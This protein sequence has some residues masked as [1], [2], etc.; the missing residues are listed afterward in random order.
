M[1]HTNT[2]SFLRLWNSEV[3]GLIQYNNFKSKTTKP[4]SV[5]IG[6]Q[7]V[8]KLFWWFWAVLSNIF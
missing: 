3:I 2:D 7:E 5:H 6:V 4:T 8:S 1:F